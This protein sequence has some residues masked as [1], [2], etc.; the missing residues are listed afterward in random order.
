MISIIPALDLIDGQ[1]VRLQQGDYEK[2]T[3]MRRTPEE[4]IR[5]YSGFSQV[6]R[7]HIVDLLGAKARQARESEL[8]SRLG[9]LTDL[10][11]EIGGGLRDQETIDSYAEQGIDYFILG[12]RAI[13]EPNWLKTMSECYPGRI[14]VGI[15]AREQRIFVNGWTE[16]S[17]LLIEDYLPRIEGLDLAG[18]IY[19]DIAKDG[20]E[21]GPNF[22]LTARLNRLTRHPVVASGGI[23]H[24]GDLKRLEAMGISEA[25]VGKACD[26]EAFWREIH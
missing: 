25:I 15:D 17:G 3:R 10:P 21:E 6:K 7:I 9:N 23:R 12:S 4:A 18:I 8:I 2:Q 26:R 19:T 20:M 13:L 1:N 24:V 16:D 11:L 5:F 14:F 22:E